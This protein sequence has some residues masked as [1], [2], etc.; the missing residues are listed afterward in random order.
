MIRQ[1]KIIEKIGKG[2]FGIVYK[3][4][5]INEPIIYVIKQISLNGLTKQ[6][7]NQVKSEAKILSLIKSNYVVKYYESFIEKEDL[8]IVMEYC[9]NGDLCNYLKEQKKKNIPLKEDLI[10]Q[11][12]IKITLGLTTIHK[13]KIL[14]RDLKTL[15]I[16]LNK[17]MGIKIGDLGVAKQLNQVSFANTLIGT[18][19]YL[20]PEMCEDKP[21]NQKSDV[22]A[23]GCILYE[24]CTFRHP[25][26]ATNHGALILKILNTNPDPIFACYSSNL[27][28]LVNQI[29]EK[30]Y[31]K[32]PNCWDILSNPIVI[33][34]AQKLGLYQEILNV[35]SNNNNYYLNNNMT[36][37]KN[38]NTIINIQ[39]NNYNNSHLNKIPLDS[40]NILLKSQLET[41]SYNENKIQVRKL[42]KNEKKI[43][44][45][46]KKN[47]ISVDKKLIRD[48]RKDSVNIKGNNQHKIH[49]KDI[50]KNLDLLNNIPHDN[51]YSR[52]TE[53]A[54]N[55]NYDLL[56]GN[57]NLNNNYKYNNINQ[58][59]IY[60]NNNIN[61]NI[62]NN[63]N[64]FSNQDL[65]N[66][67]SKY[68]KDTRINNQPNQTQVFNKNKK[69]ISD[70]IEDRNNDDITD[71]LNI[72]VKF[73]PI[74]MDRLSNK[75]ENSPN[76]LK[77]K[78]ENKN[79][80]D[81]NNYPLNSDIPMDNYVEAFPFD[82]IKSINN[83]TPSKIISSKKIDVKPNRKK[84]NNLL[85]NN[86][87]KLQQ[88][89]IKNKYN[90]S[91]T[92]IEDNNKS[93]TNNSTLINKKSQKPNINIKRE[94]KKKNLNKKIVNN[95]EK[96]DI[97]RDDSEKLLESNNKN[98]IIVDKS[99]EIKTPLRMK[100]KFKNKNIIGTNKKDN[101][102]SIQNKKFNKKNILYQKNFQEKN[103]KNNNLN[104]IINENS[105]LNKTSINISSS[106]KEI[107]NTN[108]TNQEP[109][110]I[111]NQLNLDK[112]NNSNLEDSDSD[113][114]LFKNSN[115][116]SSIN[117]EDSKKDEQKI[118]KNNLKQKEKKEVNNLENITQQTK[119]NTGF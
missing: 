105:K 114:N 50:N 27:Q 113:F 52:N 112:L 46:N 61:K 70:N 21:Y 110:S 101:E 38:Y 26:N 57:Y 10:W 75:K 116:D 14:H 15:N 42:D 109:I 97:K 56:N 40:E 102:R 93:S 107:F 85:I 67:Q 32:R 77:I 111:E 5:K 6:Q 37:K 66:E 84:S 45:E 33:E 34:K 68:A 83:N 79:K 78:N 69:K 41:P 81:F 36:D 106:L 100:E 7:I 22:W 35:F 95:E 65:N 103:D 43:I 13:M 8:N 47:C 118:P 115:S 18:P 58:N 1:Y 89:E 99:W 19:Y 91:K 82:N 48:N 53:Y 31:E 76:D 104:D 12:F 88:N 87:M 17:D 74:D 20:S 39:N 49:Y 16:F 117:N 4:K 28:K 25:F 24:L 94:P 62:V 3:V 51:N 108:A 60:N 54:I 9:D 23:L 90:T 11:I 72:S 63:K 98:N 71:S 59:N 44:K 55:N 86:K 96:K 73:G 64:M 30:N 80:N 29:L 2:A 119:E 92:S